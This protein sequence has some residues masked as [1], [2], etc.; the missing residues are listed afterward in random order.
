LPELLLNAES[1]LMFVTELG[2]RMSD[3]PR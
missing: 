1:H 3:N 2:A